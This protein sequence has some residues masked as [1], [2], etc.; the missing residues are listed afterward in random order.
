[1]EKPVVPPRIESKPGD[2]PADDQKKSLVTV[3]KV[4]VADFGTDI[5][6]K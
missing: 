2:K 5:D 4:G 1:M 6:K 3:V